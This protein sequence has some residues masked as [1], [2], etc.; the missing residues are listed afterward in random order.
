MRNRS[1]LELMVLI[2]TITVAAS[3]LAAG[4][5]VAILEIRDPT[6]DTDGIVQSLF[7]V[8][9]G[10]LGALLGL[11]AGRSDVTAELD[12]RP[13]RTDSGLAP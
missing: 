12:R 8:V 5:T 1:V 9:S 4:A 7:S 13:D 3:I 10:I 6:I 2:L 11:L